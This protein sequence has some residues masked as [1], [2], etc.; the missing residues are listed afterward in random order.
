MHFP[1]DPQVEE[2]SQR[3]FDV[4]FAQEG[5]QFV[6]QADAGEVAH[7]VH[8]HATLGEAVGLVVHAEAVAVLVAD[9][10]EDAGGILDEAQIVQHADDSV[11]QVAVSAEEVDDRAEVLPAQRDGH[12]VDG[13]VAAEQV[14]ADGGVLHARQRG[15]VVV[16][17]GARGRHVDVE[18]LATRAHP[19]GRLSQDVGREKHHGRLE[20]AVRADP[21][22]ELS[23]QTGGERDAVALDGYV[24]VDVGLVQKEVADESAHQVD[25]G[26]ILRQRRAG[27]EES[28][29][30][31]VLGQRLHGVELRPGRLDLFLLPT[32]LIGGQH[33]GA[34][35]DADHVAH[36]GRTLAHGGL[37]RLVGDHR[38]PAGVARHHDAPQLVDGRR[39]FGEGDGARHHPFHRSVAQAVPQGLVE[40]A[41]CHYADHPPVFTH[42]DTRVTVPLSGD[43]GLGDRG[44][45]VDEAHRP[46]HDLAGGRGAQVALGELLQQAPRWSAA[47]S[48]PHHRRRRLGVAAPLESAEQ[49]AHVHG[50]GARTGCHEHPVFHADSLQQ[51][52]GVDEFH[53]LVRDDAEPVYVRG[54][55]ERHRVNV[56]A[57]H[58]LEAH[59]VDHLH[60]HRP[61]IGGE[62]AVQIALYE[63]LRG[64]QAHGSGQHL[65][66]TDGRARVGERPRVLV[67]AEGEDGGGQPRDLHLA[68]AQQVQHRGGLSA[69]VREHP[70]LALDERGPLGL[71][72]LVVVEDDHLDP[73][74][75]AQTPQI[76]HPL[77]VSGV[78]D[79]ELPDLALV[80]QPQVDDGQVLPV[81]R[82]KLAHVRVE[83]AGED[84]ASFGIE[85]RRAHDSRQSV[86]IGVLMGRDDRLGFEK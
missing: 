42:A 27:P 4:P 55:V 50:A 41:P 46:A 6:S 75:A 20:L 28:A 76:A 8:V 52:L 68:L 82:H 67:D 86:E 44:V 23:G 74:L 81:Q 10:P 85:Q 53:E 49:R 70:V 73:A 37:V 22:P 21:P 65:R 35:D 39:G 30:E 32:P 48:V 26:E 31:R 13:E 1:S 54:N 11:A 45:G 78:D 64:P 19:G 83:R 84:D 66:V 33:I 24:H 62:R 56:E 18:R 7:Q 57:P 34:G 25:P 43:E 69:V 17:L 79:D 3:P 80:E 72:G 61:L 5:Y 51:H 16:E 40:V 63:G 12:G 15:R 2:P 58:A 71:F 38:H 29:E 77:G 60:E 36:P 14:L 47:E 9:R 59:H